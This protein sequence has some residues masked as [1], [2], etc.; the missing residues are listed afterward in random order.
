MKI[1]SLL[2]CMMLVSCTSVMGYGEQSGSEFY[3]RSAK[4]KPLADT[5]QDEIRVWHS[6]MGKVH[7]T[8]V[9]NDARTEYSNGNARRI[10]IVSVDKSGNADFLKKYL[11]MLAKNSR[12]SFICDTGIHGGAFYEIEGVYQGK[13]F[14]TQASW[15]KSCSSPEF[16]AINE[17]LDAVAG[18]APSGQ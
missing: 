12:Y 7:G 4:L 17:F 2:A 10:K 15:S 14:F 16:D 6:F 3:A 8:V 9:T 5:T 18:V 1:L 13:T 11:P